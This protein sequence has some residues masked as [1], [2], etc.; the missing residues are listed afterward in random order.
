M[1]KTEQAPQA[2]YER[3]RQKTVATSKAGKLNKGA[4]VEL[5]DKNRK[6]FRNGGKVK[7]R[8]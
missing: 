7:G 4:V 8:K 3:Q 2:R 1:P 5:M 6:P